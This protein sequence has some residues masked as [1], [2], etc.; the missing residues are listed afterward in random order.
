MMKKTILG[1]ST[2]SN[3]CSIALRLPDGKE[4]I[5]SKDLP[6]KLQSEQIL[7]MLDALLS[8]AALSMSDISIL[9]YCAG[10]GAFTGLRLGA[11]LAQGLSLPHQIPLY[12]VSSLE[13][14][15]FSARKITDDSLFYVAQDAR[16]GEAYVA[17]YLIVNDELNC[18]LDPHLVK[19]NELAIKV[20]TSSCKIGSAWSLIDEKPD[21]TVELDALKLIEL[22][23]WKLERG[24]ELSEPGDARLIYIRNKV[25][26]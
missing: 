1:I 5:S 6:G 8:E 3:S 17:S 15:A 26:G 21:E 23:S 4:F 20:P 14:L 12:P 16:Q 19:L 7:S 10:P 2:V 18:Q 11:A 22:A 13:S 25:T 24:S 9:V